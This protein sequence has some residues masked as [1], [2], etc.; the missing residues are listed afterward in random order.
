MQTFFFVIFCIGP[1]GLPFCNRLFMMDLGALGK[2]TCSLFT[3]G[4]DGFKRSL[5]K[6]MEERTVNSYP[7]LC[8]NRTLHVQRQCAFVYL[9]LEGNHTGGF[10]K[11][12][13]VKIS[14]R[15][16]GTLC[17]SFPFHSDFYTVPRYRSLQF[18]TN[19]RRMTFIL[20]GSSIAWDGN[21][22][23]FFPTEANS[24]Q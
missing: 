14:E 18:Y 19:F 17:H 3:P 9:L 21:G 1:T 15:Q 22:A 11:T 24:L 13:G 4:L 23:C 20:E 10:L 12:F 6:F 7:P 16:P 5:D 8:L 2:Q